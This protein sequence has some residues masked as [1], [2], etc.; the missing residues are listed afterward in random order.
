MSLI[1]I[2]FI[3]FFVAV[4]SG[5]LGYYQW[6]GTAAWLAKGLF[7]VAAIVGLALIVAAAFGCGANS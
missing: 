4:A 7:A 3:A 1:Q 6:N 2:A 5:L